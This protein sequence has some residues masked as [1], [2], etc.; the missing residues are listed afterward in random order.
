MLRRPDYQGLL[1][2]RLEAEVFE[3]SVSYFKGSSELFVRRF[4]HS[5]LARKF[6]SKDI[7]NDNASFAKCLAM[8]KDE[9]GD[10]T[11]GK[12]KI[13][14]DIMYWMGYMYRFF[15]L[16]YDIS[17]TQAYKIL[18]PRALGGV[19]PGYHTM[20]CS[21]AIERMLEARCISF[22]AEALEERAKELY[23]RFLKEEKARAGKRKRPCDKRSRI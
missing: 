10:I 11:Y 2:C 1:L 14:P 16:T 4:I 6:D 9:C 21:M 23:R 17:S 7:L 13:D 22:E 20:D 12:E 3:A 19:Y 15:C 18:T 5:S 8:L